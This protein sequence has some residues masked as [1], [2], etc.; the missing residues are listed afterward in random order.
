[1]SRVDGKVA[2]VTGGARGQGECAVRL[3]V[4]Q[5]ATVVAGDVLDDEGKALVEE[6]GDK[7]RYVHLDVTDEEQ[8]HAAIDEIDKEFGRLDVLVNNAGILK[9]G[10]VEDTTLADYRRVIDVNQIGVFL[11]MRAV[12]PVMKRGGGSIINISSVE[13]LGG[14]GATLAYS[15]SKF[16]VRGMTKVAALDLGR[17]GIRVNS[18]HPGA[19]DTQMVRE[20]AGTEGLKWIGERAHAL[21]RVGHPEEVAHVVLFLASD[22][23]SYCSG[24]EF[25]VDGGATCT[26]G[27]A[28]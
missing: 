23:S 4:G 27:F 5:G 22:E 8:W 11:G 24:S 15:A 18:V 7:A 25:V 12:A 3:L 26:A 14:S 17:H 6:L 13:G 20:H 21:K 1:M 10:S 28:I 16:A 9:F 2:L 19:I